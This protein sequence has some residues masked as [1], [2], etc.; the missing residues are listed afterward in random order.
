MSFDAA[1][2]YASRNKPA[3]AS[4]QTRSG[5]SKREAF[6]RSCEFGERGIALEEQGK[7]AEAIEQFKLAIAAYPNYSVNYCNYGNALSDL[8]R[9]SEAIEQYKKAVQLQPDFA[10]AYCNMA[11]AMLKQKDYMGAELACKSAFRVD[12]G[13]VPALTNLAEVYLNT[14]RAKEALTVLKKADGLSATSEMKKI[15]AADLRAANEMLNSA[16]ELN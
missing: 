5:R 14:N 8:K 16:G 3:I 1:P 9:Y 10:V 12:P 4:S 2:A 6:S 13:Y 11:D 15:I 7:P